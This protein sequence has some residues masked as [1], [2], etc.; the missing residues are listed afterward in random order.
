MVMYNKLLQPKVRTILQYNDTKTLSFTAAPAPNMDPTTA[1]HI[2]RLN[3]IYDPDFS[4]FGHQPAFHDKWS[5][6]YSAYRVISCAYQISFQCADTT[7]EETNNCAILATEVRYGANAATPMRT[8]G[9]D[10]NIIRETAHARNDVAWKYASN[11]PDRRYTLSGRVNMKAIQTDAVDT[12]DA[13]AFSGNGPVGDQVLLHVV[14]MTKDRDEV[15]PYRFDIKL[16]YYVE[17]SN[18]TNAENEN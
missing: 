15:N 10:L 6:L 7:A 11:D 3:S 1:R 9:K 8:E 5:A 16:R 4:T 12:L 14:K 13:I 17:L 18:A 2:F